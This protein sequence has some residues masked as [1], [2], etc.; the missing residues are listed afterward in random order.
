MIDKMEGARLYSWAQLNDTNF[1]T[2]SF[3]NWFFETNGIGLANAQGNGIAYTGTVTVSS[4]PYS[5]SYQ[6]DARLVTVTVGWTSGN[7]PR[8]RSMSTCV[9]MMGMQNYVY[10]H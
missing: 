3:T 8:T 10:N 4:F 6:A 5:T 7:V 9:T 1:L 2:P